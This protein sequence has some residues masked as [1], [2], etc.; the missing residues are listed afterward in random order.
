LR[1]GISHQPVDVFAG[2]LRCCPAAENVEKGLECVAACPPG[3]AASPPIPVTR[4]TLAPGVEAVLRFKVIGWIG[5]H[6][7]IGNRATRLAEKGRTETNHVA[8]TVAYKRNRTIGLF[9]TDGGDQPRK[10]QRGMHVISSWRATVHIT[11]WH[12]IYML[13]GDPKKEVIVETFGP[14]VRQGRA[15]IG[16][17][18]S[19]PVIVLV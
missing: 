12:R 4:A 19:A 5:Q 8:L 10:T 17:R 11:P 15:A 6:I 7:G 14:E 16:K 13:R 9:A 3:L 2:L 1:C 18:P